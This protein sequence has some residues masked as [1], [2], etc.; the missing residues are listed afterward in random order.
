MRKKNKLLDRVFEVKCGILGSFIFGIE[1][2]RI[3]GLFY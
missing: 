3:F 2:Y 1:Y